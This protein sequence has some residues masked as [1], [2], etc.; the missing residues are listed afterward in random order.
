MAKTSVI[1]RNDKRRKLVKK[2]A[3]KRADLFAIAN[4]PKADQEERY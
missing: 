3:Q 1:N 4:N 2:F